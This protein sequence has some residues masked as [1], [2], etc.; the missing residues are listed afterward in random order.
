VS[1][2]TLLIGFLPIGVDKYR[3]V[4][5]NTNGKVNNKNKTH[6]ALTVCIHE[7][8][9]AETQERLSFTPEVNIFVSD[10]K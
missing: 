4:E 8:K 2:F 9:L 6:V 7:R 1:G 5:L 10:H 3:K